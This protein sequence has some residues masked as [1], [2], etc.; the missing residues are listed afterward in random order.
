MRKLVVPALVALSALYVAPQASAQQTP[1]RRRS[2]RTWRRSFSQTARHA[3]GPATLRRCR[4]SPTRT[5]VRGRRRSRAR[6]PTGRCRRGT[7]I[8]S[9]GTFVGARELSAAHKETIAKWVA[10]GAPE[11]KACGFAAGPRLYRRVEHRHARRGV[12]DDRRTIRFRPPGRFHTNTWSS[13][14]T[15]LR[16]ASLQTG[17]FGPATVVPCTT[18]SSICWRRRKWLRRK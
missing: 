7:P 12:V 10:A 5:R 14:R 1:P 3:I 8:R 18:C 4:C 9:Y 17:R 6:L 2:T 13:R 15:S 16:I 11:G